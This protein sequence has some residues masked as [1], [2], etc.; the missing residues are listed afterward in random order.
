MFHSMKMNAEEI[1]WVYDLCFS[2]SQSEKKSTGLM[3][4]WNINNFITLDFLVL[5]FDLHKS[6]LYEPVDI[7]N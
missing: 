3:M 4:M 5:S 6:D 2:F 7:E 1:L